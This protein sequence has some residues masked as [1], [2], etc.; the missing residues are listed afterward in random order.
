MLF[1]YS[2]ARFDKPRL[3]MEIRE[4][5]FLPLAVLH[6]AKSASIPGIANSVPATVFLAYGWSLGV[7]L[8]VVIHSHH[9]FQ[10]WS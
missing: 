10:A 1:Q 6:A 3:V 4:R 8:I 7:G 9:V 2:E 5:K